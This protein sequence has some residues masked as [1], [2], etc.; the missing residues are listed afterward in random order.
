MVYSTPSGWVVVI[1]NRR[2]EKELEAMAVDIK[3]DFLRLTELIETYGLEEIHEPYVKHLQGKLWEMRM[4][5]RD[6]IARAAYVAASGKRV[7]V[8]HCFVKKTQRTPRENIEL[9]LERARE[10]G[11][12]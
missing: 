7:V 1:G 2:A 8:L 5:G 3:A 12:I 10:A 11:L 9:A 4:R 6:G